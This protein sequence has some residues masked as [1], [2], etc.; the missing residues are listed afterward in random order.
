MLVAIPTKSAIRAG[1][2]T[3]L[4]LFAFILLEYTAIV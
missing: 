2:I 3:S 1:M 4:V